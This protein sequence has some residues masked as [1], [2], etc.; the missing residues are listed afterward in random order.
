MIFYLS[1]TCTG[2]FCIVWILYQLPTGDRGDLATD[3]HLDAAPL[4]LGSEVEDARSVYLGTLLDA[5]VYV[6]GPKVAVLH[7]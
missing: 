7:K 3:V 5:Y 4:F 6:W 2:V 1:C